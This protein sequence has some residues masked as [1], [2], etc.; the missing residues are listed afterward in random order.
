MT[1]LIS[2]STLLIL[3]STLVFQTMPYS[4]YYSPLNSFNSPPRDPESYIFH[5]ITERRLVFLSITINGSPDPDFSIIFSEY[6]KVLKVFSKDWSIYD[7]P[8]CEFLRPE[9]TKIWTTASFQRILWLVKAF[10]LI[11]TVSMVSIL[12]LITSSCNHFSMH[13][14]TVPNS[15]TTIV[16]RYTRPRQT[17]VWFRFQSPDRSACRIFLRMTWSIRYLPTLCF[18]FRSRQQ[19][20][21]FS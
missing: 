12:Y 14:R 8:H 17:H 2:L 3:A 15:P 1:F 10:K 20:N 7:F 18:F 21:R 4:L 19:I 6:S 5:F 9:L 11:L 16:G 13:S